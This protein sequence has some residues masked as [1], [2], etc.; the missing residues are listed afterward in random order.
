M[1][2]PTAALD[3]GNQLLV[4]SYISKLAE[5]G[6]GIIMASHFPDHAFLYSTKS[7][8]LEERRDLCRR[9]TG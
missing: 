8:P 4:L 2:E 6:L 9:D 3:F 7:D 1:D 5:S